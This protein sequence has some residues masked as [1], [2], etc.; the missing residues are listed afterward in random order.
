MHPLLTLLFV[1][2]AAAGVFWLILAL[3][4]WLQKGKKKNCPSLHPGADEAQNLESDS[5]V[6]D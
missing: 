4:G 1:L 6:N 5:G 2:A 3:V